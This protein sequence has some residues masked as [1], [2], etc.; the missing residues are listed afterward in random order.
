MSASMHEWVDRDNVARLLQLTQD[1]IADEL[2]WEEEKQR[3]A[4]DPSYVVRY[5]RDDIERWQADPCAFIE[6]VLYNP[7]TRQPFVLLDAERA[8]LQHAFKLGDNGRLLYSDQ[9]YSCPKKSG[10]TTWAAIMILV[11]VLLYGGPF[12]ESYAL[13]ND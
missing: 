11:V 8:F 7:E 4:A 3:S 9:L 1:K 10:K 13:A 6:T 2:F 12:S 5:F